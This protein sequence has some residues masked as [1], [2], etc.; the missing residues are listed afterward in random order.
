[1]NMS[2]L[3]MVSAM[4]AAVS[5]IAMPSEARLPVRGLCAHRGDQA[6]YPENTVPAF[7]SAAQKGAAMV[8]FD[9]V[10][11]FTGELVIMHDATVDRTT[12]GKGKVSDLTFK[13]LR[14]LDAG[15]KKDSKF[16]G[17]KIPTLEEAIDSIPK[18]GIWMNVH[19]RDD[20][21]ADAARMLKAKGRLHQA[22]IAVTTRGGRAAR[23]AV[24][25][26]KLCVFLDPPNS[27]TNPWPN[28]TIRACVDNAIRERA[29]FIQPHYAMTNPEAYR[30]FH[31]YGGRINYFWCNNA[32]ELPK[33]DAIGVDFPLTDGIDA[34]LPHW[35]TKFD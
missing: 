16:K 34:L 1:M 22:F 33:L 20:V 13:E 9:V 31:D 25:N 24:P 3:R 26:V 12:D 35:P 8:E 15:V 32:E 21:A 19:C 27:W 6:A 7:R 17:T 14:A 18:D 10:R 4:V 11:C 29:E 23:E 28:A 2:R 30:V 5:S